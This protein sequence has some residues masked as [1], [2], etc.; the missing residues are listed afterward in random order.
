MAV[1]NLATMAEGPKLVNK[2]IGELN[3]ASAFMSA[4]QN[5]QISY[6]GTILPSVTDHDAEWV[7]EG[8]VKPVVQ[9]T[10]DQL[11]I[12]GKKLA[13]IVYVTKEFADNYDYIWNK[14]QTDAIGSLA[15][16]Y[17][18]TVAGLVAAPFGFTSFGDLPVSTVTNRA[19][20]IAA[21]APVQG[22][23]T[24]HIVLNEV[25]LYELMAL[26]NSSDQGILTITDTH[27]NG[28]R[29]VLAD[30]RTSEPL[31][32]VGPFATDA[33]AGVIPGTVRLERSNEATILDNGN[34]VNLWQENKVAILVE[35]YFGFRT[36][37][38]SVEN[39]A[40]SSVFRG[41]GTVESGS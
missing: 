18:K 28:I 41:L 14:I 39:S 30:L 16:T 24:S 20:F 4:A 19:S 35:G 21:I 6:T 33:F 36:T 3:K 40:Y 5:V 23:S 2:V 32:F 37:S 29:Y 38:D 10:L 8:A 27:I 26:S 15:R 34:L 25:L 7:A 12:T 11:E 9:P 22:K 1:I 31:G 17:D 13:K